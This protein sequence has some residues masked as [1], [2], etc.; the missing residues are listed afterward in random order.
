MGAAHECEDG[1]LANQ[2]QLPTADL[3]LVVGGRNRQHEYHPRRGQQ[4]VE[5]DRLGTLVFQ[6]LVRTPRVVSDEAAAKGSEQGL[7]ALRQA[8][9]ADQ[10]DRLAYIVKVFSLPSQRYFSSP[11]RNASWPAVISR[12]ASMAMPSAIS[13]TIGPNAGAQLNTRMPFTRQWS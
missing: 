7:Q 2:R 3:R 5:P 12:A 8:T 6:V 4:V 10:P 1:I 13:A 11:A 9:E